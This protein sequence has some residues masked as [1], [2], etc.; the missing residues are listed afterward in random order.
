[1]ESFSNRK[2]GV[3]H[4]LMRKDGFALFAIDRKTDEE[5][6]NADQDPCKANRGKGNG[7]VNAGKRRII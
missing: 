3:Y 7:T 6:E 1:M 4:V 5:T 2:L